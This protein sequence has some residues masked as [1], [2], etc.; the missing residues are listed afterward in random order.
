MIQKTSN[1]VSRSDRVLVAALAIVLATASAAIGASMANHPSTDKV[2]IVR[3]ETPVVK[4]VPTPVVPAKIPGGT[5]FAARLLAEHQCLSEAIYYETRGNTHDGQKAVVEVIFNRIRSGLYS[6][7]ICGVV[8]QGAN[9]GRCQFPWVCNG[10]VKGGA[11]RW[12]GTRRRNSRPGCMMGQDQLSG[13]THGAVGFHTVNV[14]PNWGPHYVPTT[15]IGG[16]I[17]YK[18]VGRISGA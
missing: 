4:M 3:V 2:Q 11:S 7:S 12:N 1:A 14:S 18:H 10:A 15:E 16:H 9:T 6:N 5:T 17:F 13:L 8:Y